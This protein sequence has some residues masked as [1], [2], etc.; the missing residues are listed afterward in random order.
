MNAFG[1]TAPEIDCAGGSVSSE[2]RPEITLSS[3]LLIVPTL[4]RIEDGSSEPLEDAK[5]ALYESCEVDPSPNRNAV[6]QTCTEC[7]C[8]S[9]HTVILNSMP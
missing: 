9:S 2:P 6:S 4:A 1:D 7:E 5:W 3:N 8:N